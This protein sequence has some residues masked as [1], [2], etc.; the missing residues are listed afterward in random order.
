LAP[1]A[2]NPRQNDFLAALPDEDYER[3]AP[4]LQA[5]N[6]EAGQVLSEP[7]TCLRY[8]YFPVFSV[9]SL[10]Y[11]FE[12]GSTSEIAGIGREGL[13]DALL[14][15]DDASAA[16]HA[17]V[18]QAGLAYRG[19]A[20]CVVREFRRGAALQRQVLRHVQT[21]FMQVAQTLTC[22]RRHTVEQRL[23]RW[24]LGILERGTAREVLATHERLACVLGV[25]RESVTATAGRLQDEGAIRYHRGRISVLAPRELE[26]RAC[27]CHTV[28]KQLYGRSLGTTGQAAAYRELA[29]ARVPGPIG[30][31]HGFEFHPAMGQSC[32]EPAQSDP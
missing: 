25:R 12:D 17:L 23:C 28:L 9:L 1:A 6:L 30:F 3:L 32:A 4:F 27:N 19:L 8:V 24:L 18:Q 21:L 20:N 29:P 16:S 10:Q 13:F 7:T 31:K 14:F 15:M 5:V 11:V 22:N 2:L 26:L